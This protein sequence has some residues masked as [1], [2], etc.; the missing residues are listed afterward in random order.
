MDKRITIEDARCIAKHVCRDFEIPS[1]IIRFDPDTK[2]LG[3]YRLI[4]NRGIIILGKDGFTL[5]T[6]LH[7][8]AHHIHQERVTD[9]ITIG[10][11]VTFH[12]ICFELR[13]VFNALYG[14]DIYNIN[15]HIYLT[16][17]YYK[18]LYEWNEKHNRS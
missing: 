15:G 2:H 9:N 8:I 6:L 4:S 17:S 11:N 10:H 5:S 7:E 14:M 3:A 13:D 1:V 18:A 16:K 12:R